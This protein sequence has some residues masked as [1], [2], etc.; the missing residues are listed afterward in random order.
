MG[1]RFCATEEAPIHRNF[2]QAMVDA[3]ER[4]TDLIFRTYRN[5]AR[6]AKNAISQE[7]VRLEGEGR[8]FQ[9]VAHLVK[10]ARG[11]EGLISGDTDHGIWSAGLVQGLIHDIPP[12]AVLIARVVSEAEAIIRERLEGMLVSSDG[13]RS[14]VA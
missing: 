1:T 7:V 5:S 3:D 4:A 13:C 6:V 10:G 2:K 8:P 12:V 14:A 9:D 11:L